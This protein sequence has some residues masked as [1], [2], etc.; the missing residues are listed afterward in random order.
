MPMEKTGQN[1]TM[2]AEIREGFLEV[3]GLFE[4][5]FGTPKRIYYPACG[6]DATPS[7]A[8]PDS[9][10]VYLDPNRTALRAIQKKIP[11]AYTVE[12]VAEEYTPNQQF[13]LVIDV[14]SFAPF[15]AE[16]KDLQTNGLLFIAN[17]MSD[18]AFDSKDMKLVGVILDRDDKNKTQTPILHTSALRKFEEEDPT[19]PK[20]SFS[21]R[22]KIKAAYYIF[23]KEKRDPQPL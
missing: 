1:E 2:E 4:Q 3:C 20:I 15:E 21:N 7:I 6:N 23:R 14:H 11:T 19:H 8:F 17:K 18:R 10:I 16:I 5:S 12:G 13:D 22:R 9:E